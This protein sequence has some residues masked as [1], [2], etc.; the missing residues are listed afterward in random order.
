MEPS[1]ISVRHLSKIYRIGPEKVV[2]LNNINLEIPAGQVV[3]IVGTSGSGK[4]TLLNQLAGLEKP[5]KGQVLIGGKNIS[6]FSENQL[7]RFRQRNIGFIFQS[8][9][10]MPAMSALEN[11]QMPLTFRGVDRKRRDK[12]AR[13][14]LRE[15]GLGDRMKHKPNQMSGGQQQRVGIARAFVATPKIIFADEPTGNLD[16][17][18]TIEVMRMMV[19]LCREHS[20]TLVIVTHDGEIAEYAD[21]IVTIRDGILVSDTPNISLADRPEDELALLEAEASSQPTKPSGQSPP[22]AVPPDP[23]ALEDRLE[24]PTDTENSQEQRSDP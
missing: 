12:A 5:T 14:I 11:V 24:T 20:Q 16:T 13:K 23:Q 10:L 15:V 17:R 22:D 19:R 6:A 21:R 7:A 18:T 9:N 1:V 3:C 4:S 2:A 8:Y